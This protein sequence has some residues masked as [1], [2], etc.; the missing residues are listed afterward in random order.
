MVASIGSGVNAGD[1]ASTALLQRALAG[2][3][4]RC[5]ETCYIC[6]LSHPDS[7]VLFIF[8]IH[9]IIQHS[10]VHAALLACSDVAASVVASSMSHQHASQ[11]CDLVSARFSLTR[12][13]ETLTNTLPCSRN[14]QTR[15]LRCVRELDSDRCRRCT[16]ADLVCEKDSTIQIRNVTSG[17][18]KSGKRRKNHRDLEYDEDQV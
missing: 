1:L 8:H 14:C 9:Y 17:I 2:T 18:R 11:K 6:Q 12:H 3:R 4:G 13:I 7:M 10:P 5:G 15:H 16:V